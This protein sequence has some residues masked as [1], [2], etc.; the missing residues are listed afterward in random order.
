M[1]GFLDFRYKNSRINLQAREIR[2]LIR[3]GEC[4]LQQNYHPDNCKWAREQTGQV[5][6]SSANFN[7][8]IP[9]K[10]MRD[11]TPIITLYDEFLESQIK[12]NTFFF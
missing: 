12:C 5:S 8:V 9:I 4:P 1:N 3:A 7:K 2:E 6:V 11:I 10:R